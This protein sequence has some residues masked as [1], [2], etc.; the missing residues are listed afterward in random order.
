MPG[1]YRSTVATVGGLPT[2]HLDVPVC[3]V[4]IVLYLVAFASHITLFRRN[5]AR[6]HRFIFS[7]MIGGFCMSRV[8]TNILRIV[9]ATRPHNVRVV[10]AA[11]IFVNAGILLIY[12]VNLVFAMRML[13]A[14]V[15][16]KR[17]EKIL[18]KVSRAFV[19]LIVLM[20]VLLITTVV[21]SV[22]TLDANIHRIDRDIQLST[23]TFFAVLAFFPIIIVSVATIL[24]NEQT[25]QP[26]GSGSW[27]AKLF[28][29]IFTAVLASIIAG[30]RAG[31]TW[32]TPRPVAHPAWYQA[33]WCFYVFNFVLEIVIVYTLL[34]LRVDLHFHIAQ[35]V[36][37]ATGG[38]EEKATHP[39]WYAVG[40]DGSWHPVNDDVSARMASVVEP[41][42]IGMAIGSTESFESFESKK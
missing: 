16:S 38:D 15:P 28:R 3:A 35:A 5:L 4:F 19:V 33:K 25:H 1:P 9:W 6:G 40:L 13:R 34:L 27:N 8:V 31:T 7:G 12:I 14:A 18:D 42:R 26:F 41:R 17:L 39:Q 2:T 32:E 24:R 21:Q 36:A 22:Y 11:N 37:H 29:V 30:F 20:L 23:T 10:L